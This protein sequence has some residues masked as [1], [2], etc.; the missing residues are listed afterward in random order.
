MLKL[1]TV[2]KATREMIDA[3]I[4]IGVDYGI[5]IVGAIVLL[6]FGWMVAGWVRRGVRHALDRIPRMDKTLKPF[7]AKL[8][9]YVIMVFVLVAVL[10]QFGVQTTSIIAV[11]GA[12]GL[13]IGLALQGT[14][15]NVASGVMLLFLRPFNVGDF[16]DVGG[17]A[18]TVVEIGLFNT[19]IRTAAGLCLIVPNSKIWS[20]PITNYSRNPTRRFDIQVGIGYGDDI[21]GAQ[22]LLMGLMDDDARVLRDPEPLVVVEQL[23]D[24]AVVLNLRAWT[25]SGDYWDTVWGLNK[26]IK[27]SLDAGG[28]SIPF[29]QRDIHIVSGG[30]NSPGN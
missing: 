7:L 21:D 27:I 13:A 29:P 28:Y 19:V 10:N 11:L 12:A 9:W 8:V 5:D 2:D 20:S 3:V 24:S 17:I 14:L 25:K 23:G 26:A 22:A 15:A 18:G 1:E 16:V 4:A 6:I 30:D